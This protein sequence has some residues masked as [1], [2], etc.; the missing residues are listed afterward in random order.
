ME[1]NIKK[2]RQDNGGVGGK[3][4]TKTTVVQIFLVCSSGKRIIHTLKISP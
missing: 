2:Q 1:T 4:L 3:T